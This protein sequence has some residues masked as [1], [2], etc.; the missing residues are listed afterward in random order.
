MVKKLEA[1]SGEPAVTASVCVALKEICKTRANDGR[2]L[3]C[4]EGCDEGWLEGWA[5]GWDVG[6]RVG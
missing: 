4:L 3:G 1:L 5:E 6:T 2:E